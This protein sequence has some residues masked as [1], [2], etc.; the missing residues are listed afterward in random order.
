MKINL[1]KQIPVTNNNNKKATKTM[2]ATN[3]SLETLLSSC[4]FSPVL[5]V[6]SSED[7]SEI[8]KSVRSIKIK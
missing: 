3:I 5:C 7:T 4:K 1:N 8:K 2:N 6:V